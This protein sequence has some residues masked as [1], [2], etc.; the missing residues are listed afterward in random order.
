MKAVQTDF[1]KWLARVESLIDAET[2]ILNVMPVGTRY[3]KYF[4]QGL[5]P[6]EAAKLIVDSCSQGDG[7]D[8]VNQ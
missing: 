4:E 8:D 6:K 1:A 2:G 3:R 7:S 5:S